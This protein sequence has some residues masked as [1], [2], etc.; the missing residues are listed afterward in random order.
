MAF[1]RCANVTAAAGGA[2]RASAAAP[3]NLVRDVL[4]TGLHRQQ[5]ARIEKVARVRHVEDQVWEV[6]ENAR[7]ALDD[8]VLRN[9]AS[10]VEV[11]KK[12]KRR[13]QALV[14]YIHRRDD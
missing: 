14:R 4:G 2:S 6:A 9:D 10:G 13:A 11:G 5:N 8:L 3:R 7:E 12:V 1:A